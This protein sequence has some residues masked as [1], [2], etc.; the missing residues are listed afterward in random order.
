MTCNE[1]HF[2][3]PVIKVI[4]QTR[5]ETLNGV[6]IFAN[7]KKYNELKNKLIINNIFKKIEE[8]SLSKDIPKIKLTT[9]EIDELYKIYNKDD[10]NIL[11]NTNYYSDYEMPVTF[12]R[13]IKK[14]MIYLDDTFSVVQKKIFTYCSNEKNNFYLKPAN[15]EVWIKTKKSK[16]VTIGNIFISPSIENR[17]KD[18]KTIF[19]EDYIFSDISPSIIQKTKIKPDKKYYDEERE[20]IIRDDLVFKNNNK[21]IL[22]NLI[23]YFNING[24]KNNTNKKTSFNNELFVNNLFTEIQFIEKKMEN[25][26]EIPEIINGYFKKHWPVGIIPQFSL[27]SLLPSSNK[28][29]IN[30]QIKIDSQTKIKANTLISNLKKEYQTVSKSIKERSSIVDLVLENE[31]KV[32]DYPKCEVYKFN[33]NTKRFSNNPF[34][35]IFKIISYFRENLSDDIPFIKYMIDNKIYFSV[36]KDAVEN[37]I[38]TKGQLKKWIFGVSAPSSATA[39]KIYQDDVLKSS[40]AQL[41]NKQKDEQRSYSKTISKMVSKLQIKKYIYTTDD[42]IRK[43]STIVFYE[44]GQINVFFTYKDG[45]RKNMIDVMDHINSL[46]KY[47]QQINKI[48]YRINKSFSI[49]KKYQINYQ[50]Y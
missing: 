18:I 30:S 45:E 50:N 22:L 33:I 16:L 19:N 49:K 32:K 20:G 27:L 43:Y 21:T 17:D 40:S 6:F 11:I 9:G 7:N 10:V 39:Q 13:F 35:D 14:D 29:Q 42:G 34:I 41:T 24:D 1:L 26:R 48:D 2:D 12:I 15:Q 3:D 31:E 37:R 44:T 4:L 36:D 38:I 28:I 46:K 47:F 23:D 8:Q 5:D 25:F